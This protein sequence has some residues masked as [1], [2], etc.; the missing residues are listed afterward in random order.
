M[1]KTKSARDGTGTSPRTSSGV[2]LR[3]DV[4]PLVRR[5]LTGGVSLPNLSSSVRVEEVTELAG[6]LKSPVVGVVTASV[7]AVVKQGSAEL[8]SHGLLMNEVNEGL[9]QELLKE[10]KS[11]R[12]KRAYAMGRSR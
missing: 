5:W 4:V 1:G 12:R 9:R 6:G 2:D 10:S 8:V 3:R 7:R 11:R